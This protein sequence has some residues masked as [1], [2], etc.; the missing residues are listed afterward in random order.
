MNNQ[1]NEKNGTYYPN[2]HPVKTSIIY[3]KAKNLDE[4]VIIGESENQFIITFKDSILNLIIPG[5]KDIY[6][7]SSIIRNKKGRIRLKANIINSSDDVCS[8]TVS[9]LKKITLRNEMLVKELMTKS[10]KNESSKIFVYNKRFNRE[11]DEFVGD[12]LLVYPYT[13]CSHWLSNLDLSEKIDLLIYLDL[14]NLQSVVEIILRNLIDIFNDQIKDTDELSSFSFSN[15]YLSSLFNS[16]TYLQLIYSKL[17]TNYRISCFIEQC[18]EILMRIII[19]SNDDKIKEIIDIFKKSIC[20]QSFYIKNV[21]SNSLI[22]NNNSNSANTNTNTNELINKIDKDDFNIMKKTIVLFTNSL[23][24]NTNLSIKQKI[25]YLKELSDEPEIDNILE[26]TDNNIFYNNDDTLINLDNMKIEKS[27]YTHNN[28]YFASFHN[29]NNFPENT[30]GDLVYKNLLMKLSS[31]ITE[32]KGLCNKEKEA[33]SHFFIINKLYSYKVVIFELDLIESIKKIDNKHMKNN[34]N[35]DKSSNQNTQRNYYMS[36]DEL[37]EHKSD[38][39]GNNINN[40]KVGISYYYDIDD[41]SKNEITEE[42]DIKNKDSNEISKKNKNYNY[43]NKD[44]VSFLTKNTL[45]IQTVESIKD[46]EEN[47]NN[48]FSLSDSSDINNINKTEKNDNDKSKNLVSKILLNKDLLKDYISTFIKYQ[49]LNKAKNII[50]SKETPDTNVSIKTN[51]NNN[52]NNLDLLESLSQYN[53]FDEVVNLIDF[54]FSDRIDYRNYIAKISNIMHKAGFNENS[55][56]LEGVRNMIEDFLYFKHI[57]DTSFISKGFDT[58]IKK[59]STTCKSSLISNIAMVKIKENVNYL[60]FAEQFN[61]LTKIS[62]YS[63]TNFINKKKKDCKIIAYNH[64]YNR[65]FIYTYKDV[66]NYSINKDFN[67]Y[68]IVCTDDCISY[69]Y[70]IKDSL[71]LLI[72]KHKV[73]IFGKTVFNCIII[74]SDRNS[75]DN[76]YKNNQIIYFKAN[77]DREFIVFELNNINIDSYDY[78]DKALNTNI[79]DEDKNNI[80]SHY[81]NKEIKLISSNIIMKNID[82]IINLKSFYNIQTRKTEIMKIQKDRIS[83][84]SSMPHSIENI[85]K[86]KDIRE[87]KVQK[88]LKTHK[89]DDINIISKRYYYTNA[90]VTVNDNKIVLI[91]TKKN[92]LHVFDFNTQEL[93]GHYDGNFQKILCLNSNSFAHYNLKNSK[94][95]IYSLKEY[96]DCVKS[97][98][99]KIKVRDIMMINSKSNVYLLKIYDC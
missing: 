69:I 85:L 29:I 40:N 97:R 8:D 19:N 79:T 9:V 38:G 36:D 17:K 78:I 55:G 80:I 44:D 14:I 63:I 35:N 13:S 39:G 89:I 67:D 7:N 28:D 18:F 92:V 62:F 48:V 91:A 81:D 30:I 57:T 70:T 24:V 6:L 26:K 41:L 51:F 94:L 10:I 58:K 31:E 43:I 22:E 96:K 1:N 59:L 82:Y 21:I 75:N 45:N 83:F 90:Y 76:N 87:F 84:I 52:E 98:N 86:N 11:I 16:L 66:V 42:F 27:I 15:S 99:Q 56:V 73:E 4:E 64:N 47:E 3:H 25:I 33:L 37:F 60:V 2:S 34:L 49:F 32:I 71:P 54:I 65:I 68:V 5:K 88:I 20:N 74:P 93:L 95:F 12:A 53:V 61:S 72:A 77:S 50:I 23:L 46:I